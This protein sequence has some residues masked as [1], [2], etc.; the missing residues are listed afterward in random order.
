MLPSALRHRCLACVAAILAAGLS[1]TAVLGVSARAQTAK[2][3]PAQ[4]GGAA[5]KPDSDGPTPKGTQAIVVLVNDEPI[6]AWEIEQRAGFVAANSGGNP[7]DMKAKAEARWAQIVKDP[8]TN[9][10]FQDYMR[11]N[12]VQS[13]EQAKAL[14]TEFVKKLQA[15][16]IDQIRREARSGMASQFRKQA[17]EEL[18]EERLKL[19]EAKRVG[20]EVTDDDV[21]RMLQ[22][23]ADRNK[24]TIE[25]FSQQVKSTGFDISTLRERLRGEQAW[26][27]AIRRRFGAQINITQ[28]DVDRM[29]TTAASEAGEDAFELQ[30][31]KVTL[32]LQGRADQSTL[33]RRFSE[34]QA[35]HSK[36]DGCKNM[37][38][39]VKEVSDAKFED[40]KYVKPGNLPEPT[41]SMLLLAK[42]GDVLPPSAIANGIEIYAVCGRRPVKGDEKTRDNAMQELQQKEFNIVAK[43]HLFDL[44]QEAHIEY[45]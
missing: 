16:M 19:Q 14:Q 9:E 24:M 5:H 32:P 38:G 7:G 18:I 21:K 3:P 25:Q 29:L 43:R 10:R 30:V 12:N 37:A 31:Q 39:L 11:A 1:M 27:E 35:L 40:S 13:Q 17:Q 34:A 26:R 45:R 28:K 15:D 44:R 2:K 20:V 4:S 23:I 41:R 42:D 36:A 8:K 22:G 6:T 33:V